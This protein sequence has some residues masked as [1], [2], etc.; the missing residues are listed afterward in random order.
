MKGLLSDEAELP[1]VTS[2]ADEP[3]MALG[4]SSHRASAWPLNCVWPLC[5][6]SCRLVTQPIR[7][8]WFRRSQGAREVWQAGVALLDVGA[9]AG[10]AANAAKYLAAEASWQVSPGV[11]TAALKLLDAPHPG[12]GVPPMSLQMAN[13]SA[14]TNGENALWAAILD[15]GLNC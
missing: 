2:G 15:P 12:S 3:A 14:A 9:E 5:C 11:R 13:V 6:V 10:A 1:L 7:L 4:F 8:R